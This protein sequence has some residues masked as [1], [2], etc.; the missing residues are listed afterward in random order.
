MRRAPRT[1]NVGFKIISL[2][3]KYQ[4]RQQTAVQQVEICNHTGDAEQS[5]WYH[6]QRVNYVAICVRDQIFRSQ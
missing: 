2:S 1:F 3:T 6:L 4:L 5:V